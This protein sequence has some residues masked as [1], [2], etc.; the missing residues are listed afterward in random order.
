MS[1]VS[2]YG[3]F[4]RACHACDDPDECDNL[5]YCPLDLPSGHTDDWER[6]AAFD[7]DAP[8]SAA[9]SAPTQPATSSDTENQS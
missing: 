4:G 3:Q 2:D 8:A 7:D 6:A 9:P 1:F 5:G